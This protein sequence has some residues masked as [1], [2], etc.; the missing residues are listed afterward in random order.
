MQRG[1]TQTP[2]KVTQC[3]FVFGT[4][5]WKT[6]FHINL[7]KKASWYEDRRS[8]RYYELKLER[9]LKARRPKGCHTEDGIAVM[10]AP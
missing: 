6:I 7:R 3:S 10:C 4:S 2:K 9:T 5:V 8:F 1:G